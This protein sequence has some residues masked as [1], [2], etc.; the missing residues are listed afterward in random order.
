[1]RPLFLLALYATAG[2]AQDGAALYKTRC[3]HCHDAPAGR[4]P[5]VSALRAMGPEL[6]LRSLEG[7]TMKTQAE[8][9][10]GAERYAL[11]TYLSSPS[12]KASAP[13]PRSAFC[14]GEAQLVPDLARTSSWTLW[15]ANLANTRFQDASAAGLT[16]ADIPKLKL[17]WSFGLGEA[18]NAYSQPSIAGGHLFIGSQSGT[19][20]SLD[21]RTGCIHWA[22]QADGPVRSGIV[23][24]TADGSR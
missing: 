20:Y 14:S 7:G 11:V 8:G 2:L 13:P 18:I 10:S 22:F 16:P 23:V 17:K 19:V 4:V 5:P 24:G 12:P 9:L 6:I 15:G 1:M 3:A 21:A